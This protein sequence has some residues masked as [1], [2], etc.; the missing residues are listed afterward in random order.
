[1]PGLHS[2]KN[3]SFSGEPR[4]ETKLSGGENVVGSDVGQDEVED[5]AFKY[6]AYKAKE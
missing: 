5:M 2:S 3:G 4:P 6:F 1:M